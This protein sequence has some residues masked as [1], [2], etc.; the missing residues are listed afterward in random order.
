MTSIQTLYQMLENADCDMLIFDTGRRIQEISIDTFKAFEDCRIAYPS[1]IQQQARFA[2][3]YWTKENKHNP[4]IWFME[5]PLDEESQ[6]MPTSRNHFLGIVTEAL[7]MDFATGNN[8]EQQLPDN[9]YIKAPDEKKRALVNAKIKHHFKLSKSKDYKACLHYFDD[10]K[11]GDWKSL[12]IQGMADFCCHLDDPK[13]QFRLDSTFDLLDDNLKLE[14]ASLL[15]HCDLNKA[16]TKRLIRQIQT[17]ITEIIA[18]SDVSLRQQQNQN[19]VTTLRILASAADSD[20][21]RALLT[22]LLDTE[23]GFSP[24]ILSVIAARHWPV[25]NDDKCLIT[26]LEHLAQHPQHYVFNALFADLIAIPSLRSRIFEHLKQA[27]SLP[28]TRL[29]LSNM[30]K[31]SHDRTH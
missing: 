20:D 15:E 12:S 26:F 28:K 3:I 6:L 14:L 23:L 8:E 16:L 1:P 13:N 27:Q 21:F 18:L 25:L 4:Y 2:L 9:P 10:I 17:L 7:G 29:A 11:T 5:L 30:V 19:I 22:A 31:N 24:D